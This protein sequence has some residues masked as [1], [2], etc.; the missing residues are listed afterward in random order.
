M[1]KYYAISV[2]AS[3]KTRIF[4]SLNECTDY[5]YCIGQDAVNT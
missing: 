5:F 4:F 3:L 1:K 2:C